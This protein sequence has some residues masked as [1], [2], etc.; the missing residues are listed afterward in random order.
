MRKK[1]AGWGGREVVK[2]WSGREEKRGNR[3]VAIG[4]RNHPERDGKR[5]KN[6]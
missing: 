6:F 2:G 4:R 5:R 3:L 1:G